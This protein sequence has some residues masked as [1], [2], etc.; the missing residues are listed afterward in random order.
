MPGKPGLA[1]TTSTDGSVRASPAAPADLHSATHP[2]AANING[3]AVHTLGTTTTR[4]PAV[5]NTGSVGVHREAAIRTRLA[6]AATINADVGR[7]Q[8]DARRRTHAD[9]RTVGEPYAS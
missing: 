4:A 7:T 5:G 8:T 2:F 3:T 9:G 1:A 6:L